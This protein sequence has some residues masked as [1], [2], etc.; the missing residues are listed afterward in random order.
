MRA[1]GRRCAE[2]GSAKNRSGLVAGV[3]SILVQGQWEDREPVSVGYFSSI[4]QNFCRAY[5]V[6]T[7]NKSVEF[8]SAEGFTFGDGV[9]GGGVDGCWVGC[10]V[11]AGPLGVPSAKV[12]GDRDGGGWPALPHLGVGGRRGCCLL[13]PGVSDLCGSELSPED[14]EILGKSLRTSHAL[15]WAEESVW[16]SGPLETI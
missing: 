2:R 15:R 9:C 14:C 7:E 12:S 16:L 6:F 4:F 10:W 5:I 8:K 1:Q 11:G 3:N 13:T